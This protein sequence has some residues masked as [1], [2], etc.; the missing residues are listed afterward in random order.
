[1][2]VREATPEDFEAVTALLEELGRPAVLGTPEEPA[3]RERYAAWLADPDRYLFVAEDGG[4][5]VGLADLWFLDWLN[6]SSKHGW[7]PDLVVTE[8]ARSRGAGAALLARCEATGRERGAWGLRLESATWRERAHAFYEREQWTH[9]GKSFNKLLDPN[10]DWP[11][12]R[13][14]DSP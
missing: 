3:H 4:A 7:I 13:P 8:A 11:P 10:L 6:F 5:V 2:E 14:E 1:V 12:P 9:S